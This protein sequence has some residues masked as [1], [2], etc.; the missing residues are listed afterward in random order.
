MSPRHAVVGL[1]LMLA[2]LAPARGQ[3]PISWE[4]ER[5]VTMVRAIRRDIEKYYYDSTYHGLNLTAHFDSTIAGIN[6]ATSVADIFGM[7]AASLL[8]LN[9]SHTRFLPP[10]W[11]DEIEYPWELGM[12]G[13]TCYVIGLRPSVP[14]GNHVTFPYVLGTGSAQAAPTAE[15]AGGAPTTVPGSAAGRSTAVPLAS[16]TP[17]P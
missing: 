15:T 17:K 2:P 7:I 16:A 11:R 9:D 8:P 6:Q 1:L 12:I 5:G 13:D 10:A 3:R 14:G 4:R